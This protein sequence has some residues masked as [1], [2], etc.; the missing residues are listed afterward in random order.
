VCVELCACRAVSCCIVLWVCAVCC[1]VY[2]VCRVVPWRNA[3]VSCVSCASYNCVCVC[4]CVCVLNCVR[5]VLRHVVS[6]CGYVPCAAMC[7]ACVVLCRGAMCR[8]CRTIE[9][10]RSTIS[11]SSRTGVQGVSASFG[12]PAK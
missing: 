3:C 6:C 5:V 12:I 2:C 8:A 1:V 7:I 9:L 4:V 11:T 10:T